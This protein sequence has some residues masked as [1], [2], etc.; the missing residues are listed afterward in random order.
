MPLQEYYHQSG[1]YI[2]NRINNDTVMVLETFMSSAVR[3]VN[4]VVMIAVGAVFIAMLNVYLTFAVVLLLFINALISH[5]GVLSWQ[6]FKHKYW[7]II[8]YITVGSRSLS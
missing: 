4:E 5:A 3:I 2:F 8:P 7:N 6:N 1:S